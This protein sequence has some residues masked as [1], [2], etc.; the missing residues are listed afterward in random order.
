MSGGLIHILM[1]K[2]NHIK[3]YLTY[4]MWELIIKKHYIKQSIRMTV[5]LILV[6]MKLYE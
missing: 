3:T 2:K 6:I 1:K 4:Y 5:T